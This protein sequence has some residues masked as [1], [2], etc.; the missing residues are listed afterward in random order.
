MKFLKENWISIS[1]IV[2]G[3]FLILMVITLKNI[4]FKENPNK[5]INKVIYYEKFGQREGFRE[6]VPQSICSLPPKYRDKKC[7]QIEE[8]ACKTHD[9]CIWL[10]PKNNPPLCRAGTEHGPVLNEPDKLPEFEWWWYKGIKYP[11]PSKDFNESPPELEEQKKPINE[12]RVRED[13]I[14]DQVLTIK[15]R[16]GGE[17]QNLEHQQKKAELDQQIFFEKKRRMLAA[18]QASETN[19]ARV[20]ENTAEALKTVMLKERQKEKEKAAQKVQENLI[21]AKSKV[22]SNPSKSDMQTLMSM[23][24]R[25]R[26]LESLAAKMSNVEP[27]R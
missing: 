20:E 2:V 6:G 12:E 21:K 10:R 11:Q 25:K 16:H 13:E 4:H 7:K 23:K 18:Q 22:G 24:T 8:Q 26:E 9:C 5:Q 15:Q 19:Q 3:L 1:L 27:Q 14:L 17:I